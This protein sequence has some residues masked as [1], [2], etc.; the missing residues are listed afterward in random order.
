MSRVRLAPTIPK[1]PPHRRR[2]ASDDPAVSIENI[3]ASMFSAAEVNSI[4]CLMHNEVE[5]IL[6]R[7]MAR[8][9]TPLHRSALPT[10]RHRDSNC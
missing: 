1:R 9:K 8:Q 6:A 7:S 3:D 10:R 5:E 2:A 4:E